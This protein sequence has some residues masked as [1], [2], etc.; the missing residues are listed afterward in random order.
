VLYYVAANRQLSVTIINPTTDNIIVNTPMGNPY[1][2]TF[3]PEVVGRATFDDDLDLDVLLVPGGA[4][5]RDPS[6]TYVDD[7]IKK[8]FPRV[9]HFIT[10][11]TGAIFAARAGVLEGR[12]ATTNKRAWDLVTAEGENITWVAPARFVRDGNLWSSSG[13]SLNT[14]YVS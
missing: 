8:M 12:R 10:V 3:G 14:R 13:V 5:S 11:C 1:N 9:K 6:M 7:Y 4:A 2:S